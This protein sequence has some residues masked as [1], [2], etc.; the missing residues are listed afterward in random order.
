M[1]TIFFQTGCAKIEEMK[2]ERQAENRRSQFRE[3]FQKVF[4]KPNWLQ[5]TSEYTVK[6]NSL[7]GLLDFNRVYHSQNKQ[8][9]SRDLYFKTMYEAVLDNPDNED[10]VVSAISNLA[11]VFHR[12]PNIIPLLEFAVS[13]YFYYKRPITEMYPGEQGDSIGMLVQKLV[14]YYNQKRQFKKSIEITKRLMDERKTDL[15]D[16]ILELLSL[17]YAEALFG[18]ERYD[19]AVDALNEAIYMYKG[20][21]EKRLREKLAEYKSLM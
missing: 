14:Y 3:Q 17:K 7:S 13:K 18:E 2:K 21:W 16:N 9:K 12:D 11:L 5:E 6:I 8:Q 4:P 19:E 15:N 1:F 20:S 10:I